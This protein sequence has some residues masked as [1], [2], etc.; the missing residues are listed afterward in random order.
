M[1]DKS[2]DSKKRKIIAGL[3]ILIILVIVFIGRFYIPLIWL[4]SVNYVS[5]FWKILLTQFWVGLFFALLFF[6]LSFIN[7]NYARRYAPAIEVELTEQD[8]DRP[9][10]QLY[11]SLQRFPISKRFVL[12]FSVIISILMGISESVNW[13]KILMYFNQVSVGMNDPIFGKDIGFYLFS[14][15]FLEY[16]RNWLS[17]AIGLIL[18]IVFLVYLAKK[19]IRFEFNKIN[20]DPPVKFHL[21][22]LLGAYLLLQA[23]AFWINSR[24]ILY[25]TQGVVYGA[26]YTD[27]QVNLLAL[28]ISMILCVIAALVI[29]VTSRQE[30][31]RLPIISIISVIGVYLILAGFLPG[32]IQRVVVSPNELAKER[33]YLS[34]EIEFTRTAY[35]LD[36][37]VES[38][39]PFKEQITY[40]EI[41]KNPET[42]SNIRLWDWRPLTQTFNQ[43]QAIRLYYE[44]VGIDVDRY[45]LNGDYQQVMV[46]ARELNS[47]KLAQEAQTWV[48][49]RLT[50][51][52]GYGVVMSPVNRVE[53][54][55]LPHLVIK[56]IPPISTVDLKITRPEIYFGEKTEQYVIVNTENREFDYPLGD[57]NVY[58]HY[59]GTGGVPISSFGRRLLLAIQFRDVNILLTGSFTEDSRIMLYRNVIDRA[60]RIAPFLI[61]DHDPYI[62]ISDEGKL[63]WILDAYTISNRF[64]YSRPYSKSFNYIRNSVK[65]II[66]AYNGNVD[67]YI[68]EPEDPVIRVYQNIFP[69][70]FKTIEDMPEDLHRHIRYPID[71]FKIQAEMYSTYHM[72]S[73]DVFYN[74]EDYWNIPNEIYAAEEIKLEPYYIIAKLPGFEKEEFILITPFTPTNKDNMISWLAAR[75][76]GEEYGKMLVYKFPKDRLVYGP[77]QIEALIDQDSEI[78]QQITLWSQSGSTVIRG[79]LLAIPIEDSILYVEPLYLRAEKGEIPQLRRIIVSDGS[80]VVMAEDLETSLRKLFG[81]TVEE[82]RKVVLEEGVT[83][84]NLIENALQFYREAQDAIREGDWAKYGNRLN[85]LEN[86]LKSLQDLIQQDELPESQESIEEEIEQE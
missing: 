68:V 24:K 69:G 82:E 19:A 64:P 61:Y 14:L 71:L 66:D 36:K 15:P 17:F 53:P 54:D 20:I 22:L 26:G 57:E 28:R 39:F 3:I 37:I 80:E 5:V 32:I 70:L 1:E 59:E 81:R 62:A 46:A 23:A 6:I 67:F 27:I 13:E 51:T 78:S 30:N 52:H 72:Q 83:V 47:K 79:N 56:D 11:K 60:R 18:V 4:T 38:D 29:F 12:G 41:L 45:Y 65:V 10:M 75:N 31:I 50:F 86:T 2:K 8:A 25:S 43:I 35:G 73:P 85:Q 77:M 40:E 48:N 63:Y 34:N 76:D 58:T 42:I 33:P 84:Q 9:E 7:F 55:G 44:F 74:K 16:F 21:S 49:E